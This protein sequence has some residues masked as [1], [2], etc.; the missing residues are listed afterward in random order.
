ML[1]FSRTFQSL[2]LLAGGGDKLISF[3]EKAIYFGVVA[4]C[5]GFVD[6]LLCFA[7]HGVRDVGD[8]VAFIEAVLVTAGIFFH[9]P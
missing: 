7:K 8:S 6:F 3:I 1:K 4:I 5:V 2:P 9:L